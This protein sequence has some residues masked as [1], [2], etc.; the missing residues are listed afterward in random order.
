MAFSVDVLYEI[1]IAECG[2]GYVWWCESVTLLRKYAVAIPEV[3]ALITCDVC[4]GVVV[5]VDVQSVGCRCVVSALSVLAW[6][7][8]SVLAWVT[9]A[10]STV[11]R[12]VWMSCVSC[13]MWW[14][15][16]GLGDGGW[17]VCDVI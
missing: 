4:G 3:V 7:A 6:A 8:L 9:E 10:C 5:L 1:W 13:P 15:V 11:R 12:W 16:V 17:W 2:D 14:P